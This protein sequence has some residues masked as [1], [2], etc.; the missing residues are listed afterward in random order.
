MYK[1]NIY[2]YSNGTSALVAAL[3]YAK[4]TTVV[5]PSYTCQDLV[6]ACQIAG[7]EFLIVDCDLDL[8]I[9]VD[10]VLN[11]SKDR[12][13]DTII[14][15]HMFG[16]Q[17]PIARIRD[18]EPN[19]TI[20]ED[21]SQAH[22]LPDIGVFSDIVVTSVNKGKWLVG[23]EHMGLLYTNQQLEEEEVCNDDK[24]IHELHNAI[25]AKVKVRKE[26]ARELLN[27]G[28]DL[29]GSQSPNVYLRGMYFTENQKRIPYIPLH[30]IYPNFDCPNVDGFKHRLDW[31]SIHA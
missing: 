13:F 29:V 20:I 8:Q 15:P 6:T 5:I 30:D 17:A 14:I 3:R 27:A 10:A 2:K 12:V 19:A 23:L 21:C 31:I 25:T 4:A 18:L 7:C 1:Q 9:S 16:I 22:G 28:I 26:R 24:S 11:L